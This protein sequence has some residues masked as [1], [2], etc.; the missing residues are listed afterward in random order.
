MYLWYIN[1]GQHLPTLIILFFVIVFWAKF[2]W[3]Q[4][5]FSSWS[6]GAVQAPDRRFNKMLLHGL[7]S[8]ATIAFFQCA[9]AL[10]S[11]YVVTLPVILNIFIP[12]IGIVAYW[13]GVRLYMNR[14]GRMVS[15]RALVC[16]IAYGYVQ[17]AAAFCSVPVLVVLFWVKYSKVV[18]LFNRWSGGAFTAPQRRFNLKILTGLGLA[19]IV[20]LSLALI[21]WMSTQISVWAIRLIGAFP[22]YVIAPAAV[23]AYYRIIKSVRE[24]SGVNVSR[25][26]L[27]WEL[28]YSFLAALSWGLMVVL[29]VYA[30][31]AFVVLVV[32]YLLL[33]VLSFFFFS[34]EI[35]VKQGG[36][37][38]GVKKIW[39]TRN[40]DGS[41]TDASGKTYK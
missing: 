18:D 25:R 15:N 30:I 20:T 16:E 24:G 22:F 34:E 3:I 29:A 4:S 1:Y 19:I 9:L 27:S 13:G 14:S 26:E 17:L 32:G 28:T 31:I 39:A 21:G 5:W 2:S 36:L 11:Y 35:T 23:W 12:I 10:F 38:G 7:G 41:Y 33:K 6:K 40:M 37:F 8:I